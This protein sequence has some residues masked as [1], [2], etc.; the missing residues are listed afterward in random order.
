[1]EWKEIPAI[2]E[3]R[4]LTY[5]MWER[6]WDEANGGN[7]S[8]ILTPDE[9]RQLDLEVGRGRRVDLADIPD[10]VRGRLIL[11]TA[12]GSHFREVRDDLDHLVGIV[13][14]PEEGDHY[15]IVRGL[16]DNLPT[17]EF[18]THL[19]A[20]AARL[21]QDPDQRVVMHNHATHILEMT[22]VG[23][24]DGRELTRELWRIITEAM[25]L[26]PDGVGFVPWCVCG[27][28]DIADKTLA[29]LE[30]RHIVVWQY[31]GV[32]TTGDSLH[33]AFGLLETVEKCAEVWMAAEAC[34][35]RNPGISDAEL[36]EVCEAFDVT[37]YPGYL[38]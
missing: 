26:F 3:V 6:G 23:P 35:Q 22:H 30:D 10:A 19:A 11:V 29:Q 16:V 28:Q 8:Y 7:I 14:I 4:E 38:D 1:M 12:T 31:H 21:A 25:V 15:E 36:R 13:R 5:L 33:S 37:P 2:K 24:T 17:S 27:T 34:G 20:H 9:V 32:L 18:P